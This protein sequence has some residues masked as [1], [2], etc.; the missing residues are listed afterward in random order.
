MTFWKWSQ[1]S[2]TNATADSTIDW[3]EGMAPSGVNDS[4][5]AMMSAAAKYRDDVSG[6]T[7]L[8]GGTTAYTF[9]TAQGLTSLTDGFKITFRCNAT[10]TGASTLNVDGLGAVALAKVKGTALVAGELVLNSIYTA[11]LDTDATDHWVIHGGPNLSY[12]AELQAIAGLT[13][14]AD[15][16]PYFTGSGTASLATFTSA[17]RDLLDDANA[18]A[19]RTTLGLGTAATQATGTSG[20][21]VPLM[22]GTNTWSGA[23]TFSNA[24]GVTAPNTAVAFG[25]ITFSGATPSVSAGFNVA[26]ASSNGTGDITVDFTNALSSNTYS[27]SGMVFSS[28]GGYT[29]NV[30]TPTTSSVRFRILEID[31]SGISLSN[32]PFSFIIQQA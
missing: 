22:N 23:N 17:G 11:T 8:A 29:I 25:K 3:A 10:N 20:A 15:R 30:H 16:V 24:A 26:S 9:T 6:V 7:D 18:A 1:T 13:S 19:Q 5:R 12:D 21:N 28:T 4:G 2:A 31:G 14:A 27:A 32:T